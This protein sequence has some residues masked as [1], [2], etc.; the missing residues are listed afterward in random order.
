MEPAAALHVHRPNIDLR[1]PLSQPTDG[2]GRKR[3]DMRGRVEMKT[4]EM[5]PERT[6]HRKREG[7]NMTGILLMQEETDVDKYRFSTKQ[8]ALQFLV[9]GFKFNLWNEFFLFGQV[10]HLKHTAS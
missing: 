5:D 7:E 3:T 4:N 9:L 1:P 10:D 8:S 6:A 2:D